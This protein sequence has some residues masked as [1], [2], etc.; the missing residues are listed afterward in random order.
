MKTQ[1]KIGQ[2][3]GA[4]DNDKTRELQIIG[5]F[6]VVIQ[7]QSEIESKNLILQTLNS[8]KSYFEKTTQIYG[9]PIDYYDE[10]QIRATDV[11]HDEICPMRRACSL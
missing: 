3:F 11:L 6:L 2:T 5:K 9:N 7:E 10:V 1:F 8:R 4:K